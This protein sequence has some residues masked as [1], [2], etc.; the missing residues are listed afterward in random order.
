MFCLQRFLVLPLPVF[1]TLAVS[2]YSQSRYVAGS[3][4][5]LLEGPA[6]YGGVI[7]FDVVDPSWFT[8]R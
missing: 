2:F 7:A 4:C 6:G 8:W 3:R 5:Q 1:K